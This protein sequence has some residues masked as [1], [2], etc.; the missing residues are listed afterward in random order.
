MWP[1]LIGVT[2]LAE[3][4]YAKLGIITGIS[5]AISVVSSYILGKHVDKNK[6]PALLQ[7]GVLINSAI[8]IIRSFVTSLFGSIVITVIN[9]PIPLVKGYYDAAD[10]EEGYRIVY[11][12]VTE[13]SAG[14]AKAA[15][16]GAL[17]VACY[18]ADSLT[19]LR[20]SFIIVGIV[21]L[22]MLLQRFPALKK[23]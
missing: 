2:V 23:V 3:D 16:C 21:S 22:G 7:F 1:L 6:G 20:F 17:F 18:F 10:S 4:T 9:E 13:I 12:V 5:L 19:V 8:H 15:Y 14:V 11:L